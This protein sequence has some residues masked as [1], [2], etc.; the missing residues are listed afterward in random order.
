MVSLRQGLQVVLLMLCTLPMPW[1]VMVMPMVCSLGLLTCLVRGY[2][3]CRLCPLRTPTMPLACLVRGT[4]RC[5]L[6][7]CPLPLACLVRENSSCPRPPMTWACLVWCTRL[8]NSLR[9]WPIPPSP[10]S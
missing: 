6:C 10:M 5:P 8:L 2:S 3:R 9:P 4:S 1:L 7:P